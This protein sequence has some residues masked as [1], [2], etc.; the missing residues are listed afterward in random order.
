MN[1]YLQILIRG[2]GAFVGVLVITR[3]VGK[4]QVGQLTVADFVNAIV[5]GSIA[6]SMVTD[7]K[8]NGWYYA[9]G[10]LLFGLLTVLAE[11]ASLKYRPL[12]KVI[13]G[14]PT[15]VIHNGKILENNMKKLI[16][17]IDDLMMQLREKNVFNISDVEFAVAEPNG[18][19]SVLLKS[20]KQPL[21]PSDMQIPT[22]YQGIPSEL[23][24]DGVVIQQNLKQNNLTEDWLYREL[25]K[26]G[27]KSVKDVMYASLDTEGNLYVDKKEDTMQH[28]TDITDKL[29]GKMPQ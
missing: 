5:L 22:K 12:R 28:V 23:I 9:F 4:S 8:E 1:P 11:Y 21:T 13:E 25:E 18:Q 19:L 24:V 6:A 29:P 26:Q 20:H 27:I 2:V 17:N 15:V 16:Y 10:L 14:E 3:V 7:L